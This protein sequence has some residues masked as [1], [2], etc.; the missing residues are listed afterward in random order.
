[1]RIV[2]GLLTFG[3]AAAVAPVATPREATL[4]VDRGRR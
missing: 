2:L 3:V 1:M 4:A